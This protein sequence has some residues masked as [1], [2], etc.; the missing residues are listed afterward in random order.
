MWRIKMALI[1]NAWIEITHPKPTKA[2]RSTRKMFSGGAASHFFLFLSFSTLTFSES[3]YFSYLYDAIFPSLTSFPIFLSIATVFWVCHL[4]LCLS[5]DTTSLR[6]PS[7]SHLITIFPASKLLLLTRRSYFKQLDF[8]QRNHHAFPQSCS[9]FKTV[10]HPLIL[11]FFSSSVYARHFW[12]TTSGFVF[13]LAETILFSP[14]I[15]E[16]IWY[17][18]SWPCGTEICPAVKIIS[19]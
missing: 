5:F 8:H 14:L 1:S 4:P 16:K 6:L 10:L 19:L 17:S 2:R 11:I 18:A 12:R 7:L 15:G 3:H 9:S 13:H